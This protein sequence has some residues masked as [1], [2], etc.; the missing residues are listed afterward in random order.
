MRRKVRRWRFPS[1]KKGEKKDR[2]AF[3]K[4]RRGKQE[5]E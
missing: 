4:K 2:V 5:R 1:K 3:W